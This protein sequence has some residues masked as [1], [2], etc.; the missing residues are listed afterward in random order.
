MCWVDTS[1][2]LHHALSFSLS[3]PEYLCFVLSP[4]F[5]PSATY[6]VHLIQSLQLHSFHSRS[7]SSSGSAHSIVLTLFS[8]TDFS[9]RLLSFPEQITPDPRLRHA[10]LHS[11]QSTFHRKERFNCDDLLSSD[12]A[13]TPLDQS[14]IFISISID[15]SRHAILYDSSTRHLSPCLDDNHRLGSYHLQWLFITLQQ[16]LLWSHFHRGPQLVC[17]RIELGS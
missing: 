17:C 6:K 7:K 10:Q 11:A 12:T 5:I 9:P 3:V 8:E 2:D 16:T 1:C 13:K 15:H 14:T 4:L